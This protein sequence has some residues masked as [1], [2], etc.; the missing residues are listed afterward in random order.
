MST[1]PRE[2]RGPSGTDVRLEPAATAFVAPSS[3]ASRA[4]GAR[5]TTRERPEDHRQ[6][7]LELVRQQVKSGSLVIRQM[8][9]DER[10]WYQPRASRPTQARAR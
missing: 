6:E 10:R 7:K 2:E 3:G 4:T 9:E 5:K 1:H 8:T